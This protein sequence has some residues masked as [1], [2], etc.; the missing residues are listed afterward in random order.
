MRNPIEIILDKFKKEAYTYFDQNIHKLSKTKAGE[1]DE[2]GGAM[3]NNDA[4]AFRHAYAS[5]SVTQ[6]ASA[7]VAEKLGQIVEWKGNN[8]KNQKNMDL[9]NNSIGRKYGKQTKT[10]KALADT[11]KKALENGELITTPNDSR[12]YDGETSF[13]VD[14]EKP[15]IVLHEKETGRNELFLDLLKGEIM[16]REK[17]VYSINNGEYPGYKVSMIDN[18]ATPMSKPDG[19]ADNNLG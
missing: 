6:W 7:Y 16:D 17:F 3:Q 13:Q 9:W 19:R 11:L 12:K 18:I 2:S 1:F 4:D 14:T 10:K 8:P 15:I 5:G